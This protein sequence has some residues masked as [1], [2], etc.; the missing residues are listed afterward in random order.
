MSE[1]KFKQLQQ[2][3]CSKTP[4]EI[5]EELKEPDKICPTC[6]PNPSYVEPDWTQSEEPYLNEKQCE[7]Q[8]KM[9]INFDA[10]IYYDS[11][12]RLV[13]TSAVPEGSE[14]KSFVKLTDSPYPMKTLLKSY[15]RPAV[16][17][18]LRF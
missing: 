9:M 10:D 14:R 8:V 2:D 6:I 16:R 17:K 5:L 7:Y 18:M 15:I 11:T 13:T 12:Q 1:S 3:A 4:E